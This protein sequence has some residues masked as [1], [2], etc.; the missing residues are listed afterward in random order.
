[1]RG[2]FI[3]KMIFLQ[4]E[5][6]YYTRDSEGAFDRAFLSF[7]I[8]CVHLAHRIGRRI[9]YPWRLMKVARKVFRNTIGT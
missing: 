9:R 3:L 5:D 2:Y 7:S 8:S 4:F 1:M 6:R